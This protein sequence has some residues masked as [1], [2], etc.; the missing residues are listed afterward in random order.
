MSRGAT[1]AFRRSLT[2]LGWLV[3]AEAVLLISSRWWPANAIPEPATIALGLALLAVV[4]LSWRLAPLR[5]VTAD[6]RW[7]IAPRV[8]SGEEVT[9]GAEIR[10]GDGLPPCTISAW[11]PTTRKKE[12]AVRLRATVEGPARPTWTVRFP[13]RGVI[14]LPALWLRSSQPFGVVAVERA[15]GTSCEVVVLPVVGQLRKA[16]RERLDSWFDELIPT[17]DAGTDEFDHLRDYRRGD[18]LRSI[19]WRASARH[20]DLLVTERQDPACRRLAIVLDTSGKTAGGV[21]E[22]RRFEKLVAATAT[23]AEG[24]LR[25]GWQV[26]IHGGFSPAGLTGELPRLLEGLALATM[27]GTGVADCIPAQPAVAVF[28]ANPTAVPAL[29]VRPLILSFDDLDT[30]FRLPAR[31]R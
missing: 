12:E 4:A 18:P 16:L 14:T 13:R 10:A 23:L 25:R 21:L 3:L 26:S 19:H 27:D 8:P 11:N 6:A 31:L 15:L 29:A 20:R 1:P 5:V 7:V 30:L 9:V 17:T 28:T 2:P 22:G 24:C